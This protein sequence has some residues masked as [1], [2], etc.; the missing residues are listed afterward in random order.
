MEEHKEKSARRFQY[1]LATLMIIV[2]LCAVEMSFYCWLGPHGSLILPDLFVLGLFIL[3][4]AGIKN[5]FGYHVWNP[6]YA[7]F[8]VLVASL[9]VFHGLCVPGRSIE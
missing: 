7:E 6:S 3:K 4:R 9:L 8:I 2:T 1:S 5:I